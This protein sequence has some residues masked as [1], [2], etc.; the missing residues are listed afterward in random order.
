[1]SWAGLYTPFRE[2]TTSCAMAWEGRHNE[3]LETENNTTSPTIFL[4]L[5]LLLHVY[6][7]NK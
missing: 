1:M 5:L 3:Q 2:D 4:L 7:T 6:H